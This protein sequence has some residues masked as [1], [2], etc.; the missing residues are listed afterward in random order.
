MKDS[1]DKLLES[2]QPRRW[3]VVRRGE[4]RDVE[5]SHTRQTQPAAASCCVAPDARQLYR[6]WLLLLSPSRRSPL[7]PRNQAPPL[8]EVS[9]CSAD[10]SAF[11]SVC[12]NVA[13][14]LSFARFSS[15]TL[16]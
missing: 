4:L 16:I 13:C 15:A 2:G 12:R 11:A 3:P 8:G 1:R 9:C 10:T 6:M 7:P 5:D 14:A